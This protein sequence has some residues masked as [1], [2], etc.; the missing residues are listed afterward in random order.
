MA[1]VSSRSFS[2]EEAAR[3]SGSLQDPARMAQNYAGVSGASDDRN[4]II[5]RGN[6][7]T[8]VLWRLEG[9]DIPSPNHF[10]ALGTT[11]GPV[12]MLNINNLRNSDFLTSAFPAEYGNALAGVFDLQL[13]KGNTDTYEFL[14]Q[15]GFNGFEFGAEG[16]FKK[17]KKASFLANYRYSTLGLVS[18]L[19][20][21]LGTGAA[22]PQYQD[23]TWKVNIPTKKAGQ[24][25]FFG[26][27]GLSNI[28]FLGESA[29]ENNLY[30]NGNQDLRFESNTGIV[31]AK[32]TIFLDD[33]T[34]SKLVVSASLSQTL[35]NI[36][37]LDEFSRA[38][39]D[40]QGFDRRQSKVSANYKLNRKFNARNTANVGIIG[41][42]Y[43]LDI[44][45]ST[46]TPL[47]TVIDREFEGNA[48]LFQAYAQWKHKFSDVLTLNSGLHSQ[49][50]GLS[51][52]HAIEPRLSLKYQ[53]AAAHSLSLGSGMHSQIQPLPV[54][55]VQDQEGALAN[56][57]VD[58]S[59]SIHSVLAYDY[60]I[61][62]TLRFKSEIYYQYLYQIPIHSY[63]SSFSMLNAGTDFEV[64]S[65]T[66]LV[67]EG[68][69]YNYGLELTLEKFYDKGYYFL[70]T[71]SLFN[72]KYTGSDGIERNTAF[73]GNYVV[74]ALAGT[75]FQL[76]EQAALFFD[77]K[78]T[79][80]GGRRYTP[81]DL[82]R[83]R[84]LGAE[85]RLEEDAFS[86]QFDPYFRA[87]IKAGI[88]MNHRNW[89][90]QFQ[91][92]IQNVA[93][94]QNIFQ[95]GYNPRTQDI[96]TVYQRGLFPDVQYKVFF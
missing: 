83:S 33:K 55:F 40:L 12:S 46:E 85:V 89:A 68:T 73:N 59:R 57:N 39:I 10:A 24:F 37:S 16:P 88:R 90:Q 26:I 80:A 8:G 6:S 19:G 45:D 87:D 38:P 58:F 49:H 22:V 5:I 20:V 54:Y 82:V 93:N 92:D 95:F 63:A 21:S 53:A 27:G 43:L 66:D 31:G 70:L 42:L 96:G 36:D 79:V 74:N 78:L 86:A 28:E 1:T 75:E 50:F 52:S 64:P 48:V 2:V 76:S 67:N 51:N 69:G 13:R 65:E 81:I 56:S 18:A 29:G 9:I 7:P 72:S 62:P 60:M 30:S 71:T 77:T 3:Y 94:Y 23:L 17:G 34:Y 14:G 11:G 25:S 61:R 35:G 32:H 15:V 47:G 41:D 91:V 4:D 44:L 84:E